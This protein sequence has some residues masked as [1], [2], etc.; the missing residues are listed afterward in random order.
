MKNIELLEKLNKIE[1]NLKVYSKQETGMEKLKELIFDVKTEILKEDNKNL[2]SKQRLQYAMNWHKKMLK[3]P[4]KVLAYC[5]NDQ[6]EDNQV[7][8]DGQFMVFLNNEDNLP[9]PHYTE[10]KDYKAS[11]PNTSLIYARIKEDNEIKLD[12]KKIISLL[13]V[14]DEIICEY[15]GCKIGFDKNSFKNITTFLNIKD[16][17]NIKL[18]LNPDAY[19]LN[20]IKNNG[21]KG[22]LLIRKIHDASVTHDINEILIQE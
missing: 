22:I 4:R 14:N 16:N 12:I 19:N 7:I 20:F 9:L 13:K 17:S 1:E 11:Y 18:T 5:C 6:I 8:T 2:T 21:S 15:N 10:M 3:T